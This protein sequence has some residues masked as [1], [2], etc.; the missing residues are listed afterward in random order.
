[1]TFNLIPYAMCFPIE[2]CVIYKQPIGASP[3]ATLG[4]KGSASINKAGVLRN[5][6][7]FCTPGQHVL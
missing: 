1:M 4:E 3:K 2:E 7:L 5:E 6:T